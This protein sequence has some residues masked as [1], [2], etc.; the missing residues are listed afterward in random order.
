[1]TSLQ[2]ELAD[3]SSRNM[4]VF[5]SSTF[6][7][8]AEER[9]I[10]AESAFK[11][12]K[13]Y[14]DERGVC[15][16]AIDLR[17]GI[18]EEQSKSGKVLELCLHEIDR[19][20]PYFV[21][22]ISDRYGW[23]PTF[24]EVEGNRLIEREEYS[25]V[26][27]ATD[28]SLSITE[29]EMTYG[30]FKRKAKNKA[31]FFLKRQQLKDNGAAAKLE[32]LFG[33][34]TFVGSEASSESTTPLGGDD[35][36]KLEKL[37]RKIIDGG[38]MSETMD[39][40]EM[41]IPEDK[42]V[43]TFYTTS[44]GLNVKMELLMNSLI[45]REFPAVGMTPRQKLKD[46]Q[47]HIIRKHTKNF[48]DS[49]ETEDGFEILNEA[50]DN[51]D[52]GDQMLLL[53]DRGGSGK[54]SLLAEWLKRRSDDFNFPVLYYFL[55]NNPVIGNSN[56]FVDYLMQ[57]DFLDTFQ[58]SEKFKYNENLWNE[59]L[60]DEIYPFIK[61]KKLLLIVD[62]IDQF[63]YKEQV[64]VKEHLERLAQM[65]PNMKII[66]SVS[67]E[68]WECFGIKD[69]ELPDDSPWIGV[70]CEV[71]KDENI[72]RFI[73][74]YLSQYGKSLSDSQM[75]MI[76]D[77]YLGQHDELYQVEHS[78]KQLVFLL[79]ELATYGDFKTLTSYIEYYTSPTFDSTVGTFEERIVNHYEQM[80]GEDFVKKILLPLSLRGNNGMTE[81]E[82]MKIAGIN[83]YEWEDFYYS[84]Q[85]YIDQ[86]GN[87][88]ILLIHVDYLSEMI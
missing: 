35:D 85:N 29:M 49:N 41:N 15:F 18:T 34:A 51:W 72:D 63:S 61:D 48:I 79:E 82:I 14:A 39:I 36:S 13:K 22:L 86:I 68:G 69:E 57:G 20:Q 56:Y 66:A 37:R 87:N 43:Y 10:L 25:W 8:M 42:F 55:Q 53:F 6:E 67:A 19:A 58:L 78:K 52:N 12:T 81:E 80:F 31:F 50:I 32:Q 83:K 9:S 28:D 5:I 46:T 64:S 65:M 77:W 24:E 60:W 40:S 21:G 73:A 76:V 45:E 11:I 59:K 33:S 47:T 27:Q 38:I 88:Y 62:G 70:F 71:W 2:K 3:Y 44:D 84:F 74:E 17:W 1:M 16:N 75:K 23:Q 7:N 26:R 54:T 4:N 30:V